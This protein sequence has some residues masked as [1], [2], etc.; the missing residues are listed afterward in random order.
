MCACFTVCGMIGQR[1]FPQRVFI[2]GGVVHVG[3]DDGSDCDGLVI[4]V[5]AFDGV[6][7]RVGT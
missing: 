7:V 3:C 1:F 2:V 4:A 6:S 5:F